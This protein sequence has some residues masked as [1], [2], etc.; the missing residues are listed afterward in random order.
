[1]PNK[2]T[3]L[4]EVLF[5]QIHPTFYPN[6]VLGSPAFLPN[7]SD[8]GQSSNDRGSIT[9]PQ[10]AYNHYTQHVGKQSACV[11]GVSVAEYAA[12]KIDCVEDPLPAAGSV[13]ANPAHCLAD[14]RSFS[15]KDQKLIAKRLKVQALKRGCLH[16]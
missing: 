4:A 2:L 15:P 7:P 8:N 9:D 3:D 11:F 16:P 12:E 13:P 14:Y 10:S 6:G 5:R 1:M